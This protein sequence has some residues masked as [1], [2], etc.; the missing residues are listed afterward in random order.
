MTS[1]PWDTTIHR[2]RVRGPASARDRVCRELQQAHWPQAGAEQYVFVRKVATR[3]RAGGITAAVLQQARYCILHDHNPDN[4]MR[5]ANLA[6]LL[7]ALLTDLAQGKAAGRWYWQRWAHL[8]SL[9][10]GKA[11]VSLMAEHL[12]QFNT[13][14]AQ[15]A[16]GNNL[17]PVWQM[18]QAE[19]AAHLIQEL[20]WKQGY[21]IAAT[22]T[23]HTHDTM[24]TATAPP[25][26]LLQAWQEVTRQLPADDPRLRLACVLV[27]QQWLPLML[28][29]APETALAIVARQLLSQRTHH[30]AT[31]ASTPA[32]GQPQAASW[33]QAGAPDQSNSAAQQQPQTAPVVPEQAGADGAPEAIRSHAGQ[34]P[35]TPKSSHRDVG[36]NLSASNPL[37]EPVSDPVS[38]PGA[39][40]AAVNTPPA[41]APD[42]AAS[43]HPLQQLR[44]QP[45]PM[46]LLPDHFHT[47]QGGVLYLLNFLNR[48]ELQSLLADY[49]AELPNGWLWLY[50]VAQLLQFDENDPL[51]FFIARQLDLEAPSALQTL[52]ALPQADLVTALA[53]QWYGA[54]APNQPTLWQPSLLQLPATIRFSPSHVD[55]YTSPAQVRIEVRLAGLDL[56]PGWLPWLGRVVTFH[57]DQTPSDPSTP[58][59]EA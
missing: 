48:P 29:Q 57:F 53:Q 11:M 2:L 13:V 45:E 38:N 44:L 55:L 56:N 25:Q 15:L 23:D 31:S 6:E 28:W 40:P 39:R 24:A 52:P 9:S 37:S 46:A 54:P 58:R 14:L 16:Q 33:Q 49:W 35:T 19:D 4:V 47:R 18:L 59:L 34:P 30:T 1:S 8:F 36:S 26:R 51:A 3:A 20:N 7:A 32:P 50:R 22:A 12:E 27:A 41:K 43:T 10:P 42:K 5:F 17:K 21:Q